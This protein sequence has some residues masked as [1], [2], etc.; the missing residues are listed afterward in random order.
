MRLKFSLF[1]ILISIIMVSVTHATQ[2]TLVGAKAVGITYTQ[3]ATSKSDDIGEFIISSDDPNI[4]P[5]GYCIEQDEG[6]WMDTTYDVVGDLNDVTGA[7]IN[8]AWLVHTYKPQMTKD[9]QTAA[10]QL[11]IWD[12]LD[13]GGDGLIDD[14]S[15]IGPSYVQT[16]F[17]AIKTNYDDNYNE[18]DV[19]GKGYKMA[20]LVWTSANGETIIERQDILVR[21]V[22][23]PT[24]ML[25]FGF[26]L[27][28]LGAFGRRKA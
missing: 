2:I 25:L 11:A 19:L 12:L 18:N 3:N 16:Y 1:I 9:W 6:I 26:G 5:Y 10:L 27:L 13:D 21:V 17:T 23:E 24:S 4:A 15:G 7:Y 20:E 28:G 8:A 22:P 14:I